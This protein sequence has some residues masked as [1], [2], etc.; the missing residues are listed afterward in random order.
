[1]CVGGVHWYDLKLKRITLATLLRGGGGGGR[2]ERIRKKR[3]VGG[4][5]GKEEVQILISSF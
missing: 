5:E 2:K 1:M 4:E 3:K